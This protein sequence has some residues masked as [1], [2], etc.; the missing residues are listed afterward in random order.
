MWVK[1]KRRFI[2]GIDSNSNDPEA[3]RGETIRLFP[4]VTP[5]NSRVRESHHRGAAGEP[6]VDQQPRAKESLRRTP[7]CFSHTSSSPKKKTLL[8]QGF[9]TR[10]ADG[11]S[12]RGEFRAEEA[13]VASMP[14]R[15]WFVYLF[16]LCW[17]CGFALYCTRTLFKV[18]K[19]KSRGIIFN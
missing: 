2:H 11:P 16:L 1:K 18:V 10:A 14:R 12:V 19:E 9:R 17:T 13:C 7:L 6:V 3:G 5:G 8:S 4:P 15:F